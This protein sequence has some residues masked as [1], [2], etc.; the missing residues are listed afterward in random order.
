V[1]SALIIYFFGSNNG[2]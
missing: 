1:I 2:A